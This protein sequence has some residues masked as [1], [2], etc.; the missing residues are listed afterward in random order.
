MVSAIRVEPE[1]LAADGLRLAD[2]QMPIEPPL[3]GAPAADPTSQGVSALLDSHSGALAMVVQHSGALRAHGGA[4]LAQ[5]AAALRTMDDENAALLAAVIS[6]TA[7]A[8][9]SIPALS[10]PAA[11]PSIMLP[12]PPALTAPPTLPGEQ[13]ASLIHRGEGSRALL[14]FADTWRSHAARLDDL[15]DQVLHRS[16]AIDEHWSDGA[17]QAGANTREHGAWLRDS[18][19][20]AHKIA[21]VAADVA[22]EF[23]ATKQATPRPQEFEQARRDLMTAQARRDPIGATQAA[24]KYAALQGQA[25]DAAM[26][27]HGGV[28]AATA[29][30]GDPL[31]TA[32]AIARGGPG[33]VQAVD[34]KQ[35]PPP[36]DPPYPIND[37]IAEATDLDGNHV[38]LRRGYYDAATKEGFGWDKIYWK[39]GLIN[40]NVFKDL[41]S[42]S[43]PVSNQ[44]GTLVYEVPINKTHCTSGLFGLFPDCNDTGESLT[45]RIVAN[46]NPSAFVPGG[47]QKG[48]ITMYPLAGGS[49]V[50]EVQKG[51][52]LTPPWINNYVP[53]N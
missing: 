30:L 10:V 36:T 12:A 6:G 39:H 13:F 52:T 44:G 51:W 50:V 29:R 38:V 28:S 53:I 40:P 26:S 45:M 48:V 18:A 46:T 1:A 27:Y 11:P 34:F 37:V 41:I 16:A 19:D 3:A 7:P 23:D 31:Q 42:H 24:Q 35:A 49:G 9:P 21:G 33:G 17:Q 43:R 20:Q 2:T 25:T 15:A 4:V 14:D 8:A 22:D 32:P 5:G 47:G